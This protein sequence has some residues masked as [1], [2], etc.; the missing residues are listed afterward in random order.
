[1]KRFVLVIGI[2]LLAS[3]F[4]FGCGGGGEEGSSVGN[5]QGTWL[6]V[7]EDD[8]GK[9]KEISLTVGGSGTIVDVQFDGSSTGDTGWISEDW[10]E[11]LFHV[12]YDDNPGNTNPLSRGWMIVDYQYSH[13][14]YGDR[15]V[16]GVSNYYLGVLEKGATNFPAYFS[17]DIVWSYNGG[18]YVF[19]VDSGPYNWVGDPISMTVNLDLTFSGSSQS[20]SSS[21]V[22]P[23]SG[24]FNLPLRSPTY[25]GYVCTMDV[26]PPNTLD[27]MALVSP[28]KTFIAAYAKNIG[29]KPTSLYD[30]MLIGGYM[31]FM[32]IDILYVQVVIR[33]KAMCV[34]L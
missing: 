1:M 25:G 31:E 5:L 11:N 18:A 17:S 4:Y 19:T 8:L 21:T 13:A 27:I 7:V 6:G 34:W 10:D 12:F 15:G 9:L 20:S 32:D 30:Y 28:D 23:F 29:T 26:T 33:F 14:T 24:G 22:Y 3:L 16:F 2:S